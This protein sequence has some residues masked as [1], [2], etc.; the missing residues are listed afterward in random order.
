MPEV[1]GPCLRTG[2]EALGLAMEDARLAR[3]EAFLG[4]LWKW[5]RRFNL[6]G[7]G[8]MDELVSGHVLD[9]LSIAGFVHGER[10]LDVGTGAGFPG[11]PLALLSPE[12]EFTLLDSNGK[13]TR[14]LFQA[15][16]ELGLENVKIEQCRVEQYRPSKPVDCLVTRAVGEIGTVGAMALP[17]VRP[18]GSMV[19]MKGSGYRAELEDLPD[20]LVL[21]AVHSLSV[22]GKSLPRQ[23]V[24]LRKTE[25]DPT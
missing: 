2:V 10:V 14:F 7:A 20:G 4:L 16:A 23:V 24:V 22:P 9:S 19:F 1:N 6:T 15:S 17:T 11:I 3:L 25:T 5:N 21:E 13:K 12:R 8:S 18:G